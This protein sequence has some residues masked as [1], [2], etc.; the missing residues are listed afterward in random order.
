MGE[1]TESVKLTTEENID[2]VMWHSVW[3]RNPDPDTVLTPENKNSHF[4]A[5]I[6]GCQI[7]V[8]SGAWS[9]IIYVFYNSPRVWG[10]LKGFTLFHFMPQ[11]SIILFA[12]RYPDMYSLTESS[13]TS[14]ALISLSWQFKHVASLQS[15][16]WPLV[17]V[18]QPQVMWTR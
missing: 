17:K 13:I 4:P 6:L 9:P 14:S 10:G 11:L 2:L 1:I 16:M 5:S 8:T 3:L 12:S 7:L 15:R 18:P